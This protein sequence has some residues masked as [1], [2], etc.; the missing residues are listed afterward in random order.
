MT[1][2]IALSTLSLVIAL[3]LLYRTEL[4]GPRL[5]LRLLAAPDSWTVSIARRGSP[6]QAADP[7]HANSLSMHGIFALAATNDGPRG[8]ALWELGA[9]V[10]GMGDSWDLQWSSSVDLP[11]ALPG[12][13]CEGWSRVALN[14]TCDFDR[15]ASGL[16][17]LQRDGH[18]IVRITYAC[19]DW[20]GRAHHKS[21]SLEVS[22]ASLLAGLKHGAEKKGLDLAVCQVVPVARTLVP[23]RF[24]ELNLPDRDIDLLTE[25]AILKE[26]VE[27]ITVPDGAPDRVAI[28]RSGGA[29]DQGWVVGVGKPPETL[30]RICAIQREIAQEVKEL[31]EAALQL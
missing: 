24:A 18:V 10:Q 2:P 25:W 19:Q 12:R 17:A 14:L 11:Y 4:R 27:Y 26:P 31:R 23:A 8:G 16:R 28:R 22:R 15:L 1:V 29:V 30:D 20:R 7:A 3:F 6:S 21:T 9:D 13:S 5:S